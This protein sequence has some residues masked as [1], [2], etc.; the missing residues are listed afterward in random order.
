MCVIRC[1]EKYTKKK[2]GPTRIGILIR[3]GGG[4][5]HTGWVNCNNQK[6]D[7]TQMRID[8][9]K[10]RDYPK[11]NEK[12]KCNWCKKVKPNAIR[13]L[14][15]RISGGLGGGAPQRRRRKARRRRRL[16]WSIFRHIFDFFSGKIFIHL[17]SK[18][19]ISPL[20]GGV[21]KWPREHFWNVFIYDYSENNVSENAPYEHF[22]SWNDDISWS[23]GRIDTMRC[24]LCCPDHEEHFRYLYHDDMTY[25]KFSE[26]FW[27]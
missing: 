25:Q 19:D 15:S 21:G 18:S 26:A 16:V 3:V 17:N 20:G 5:I 7:N 1:C 13:F 22:F 10:R 6:M 4:Y 14:L 27:N 12:T 24:A 23:I 2:F 8:C 11:R 9:P